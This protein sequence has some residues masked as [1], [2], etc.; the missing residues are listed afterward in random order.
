[1]PLRLALAL[2]LLTGILVLVLG[3][4]MNSLSVQLVCF[5]ALSL[6]LLVMRG[7]RRWLAAYRVMLPF[8]LSLAL[9]YLLFGLLK[10]RTQEGEPGSMLHWLEFG[11][12]RVLLFVNSVLAFQLFFSL[13]TFDDLLRLP[14]KIGL[15]KYVILGKILFANAL[16]SYPDIAFHHSLIPT[17]QIGK[18]NLAKRFRVRLA[19]VL[20]LLL[21]LSRESRLRG[22][23][24]DNRIVACHGGRTSQTGQW[25]L[26]LG[27][28]VLVT[29]ATMI[30]PIPVPGGGFFNFGDV[31]IVFIGLH[32]GRKAGAIAG[33]IGS[34]I[35]DLLLFPLFAP[36][37][38]IVKGLEGYL[39]GLAHG[40]SGFWKVVLPLAGSVILVAGY[41]IGE[42][43]LPQLGKA[44]ALAD[45][46]V[47]LVQAAV[48]FSGG[49]AL[50]EATR[51]LD[52]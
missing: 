2:L 26:I 1:M 44:V 35:A 16:N 12:G 13:V 42:W 36:I 27:F 21:T 24:I 29:V 30:I 11:L 31:M 39:C 6:A 34:A 50:F 3:V 33:G 47:N 49:R 38:L 4:Y 32:A 15:L 43:S 41:F 28:V 17:E 7:F 8:L 19:A 14:L 20:A 37:T 25:Y 45:L 10:I 9:V 51:S 18:P 48:G 23:Q 52:L 46:P 40:R 22:E 5:A